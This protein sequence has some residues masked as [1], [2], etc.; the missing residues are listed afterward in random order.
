MNLV[1]IVLL[2]STPRYRWKFVYRPMFKRSNI[3]R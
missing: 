3:D 1:Q 2:T